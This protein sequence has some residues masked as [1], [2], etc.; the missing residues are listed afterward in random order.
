[1]EKLINLDKLG[2][3]KIPAL[4]TAAF[5]GLCFVAVKYFEILKNCKG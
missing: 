2:K 4:A 1:M 3:M 5:L